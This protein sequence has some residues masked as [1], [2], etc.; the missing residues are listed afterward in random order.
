MYP[1][2][3]THKLAWAIRLTY[4]IVAGLYI[5]P[6]AVDFEPLRLC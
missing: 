5:N 6:Q 3:P 1:R 2:L 4:N